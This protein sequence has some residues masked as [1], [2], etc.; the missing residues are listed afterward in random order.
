MSLQGKVAIVTGGSKGIGKA[1]ALKLV[2]E[3]ASVVINYG[4]D[5]KAA[6]DVVA[7]IGKNQ[8]LAVQADAGNVASLEQLVSKTVERF[9]KIDILVANAG[10]MPNVDLMHMTE[11]VFNKV[12]NLNVKGPMFLAQVRRFVRSSCRPGDD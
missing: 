9:G 5:S 4:S 7:Q 11:E 12:F 3:G 1:T 10:V 2:K 8:A 6:D